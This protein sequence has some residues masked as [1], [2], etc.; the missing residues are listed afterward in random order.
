[1]VI[2][3]QYI[4]SLALLFT[5]LTATSAA[6]AHAHLQ[7]HYP[8]ENGENRSDIKVITLSFSESIEPNFSGAKVLGP[9]QTAVKIGN[10]LTN[11]QNKKQLIIPVEQ[12]LIAGVYQVEWSVVSSDGHKTRGNYQFT[13]K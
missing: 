8:T 6:F 7:N 9:G 3:T 5:A 1:M 11:M 12:K 2:I 4:A 10:A 13:V